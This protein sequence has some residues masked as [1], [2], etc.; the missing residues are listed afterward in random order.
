M[1]SRYN[2][3]RDEDGKILPYFSK[4]P[5]EGISLGMVNVFTRSKNP[6]VNPSIGINYCFPDL[7][8]VDRTIAFLIDRK[9]PTILVLPDGNTGQQLRWFRLLQHGIQDVHMLAPKDAIACERP[10]K[11]SGAWIA[12][13]P[14]QSDMI[15]LVLFVPIANRHRLGP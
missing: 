3:Q 5:E 12:G 8:N 7:Q 10:C 9:W 11:S 6:M 4:F 13:S 1:A 2:T 14:L 15:A